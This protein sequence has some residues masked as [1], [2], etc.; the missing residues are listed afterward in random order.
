MN[1]LVTINV[2]GV[3]TT[4][5]RFYSLCRCNM[6]ERNPN[7]T[8]CYRLGSNVRLAK[9]LVYLSFP[10]EAESNKHKF[11]QKDAKVEI[12]EIIMK[13]SLC[14]FCADFVQILCRFC[15]EFVQ[16]LC[17]VCADFVQILCIFCADFVQILFRFSSGFVQN[18]CIDC[19]SFVQIL[20][21][22]CSDFVQILCRFCPDFLQN[23]CRM[24]A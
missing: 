11:V 17:R 23:L 12:L 24:C 13:Y 3:V 7:I 8:F 5:H 10:H 15:P 21:R 16:S 2:L 4:L 9:H 22:F 6:C 19:A 14:R 18:V 20:C 1:C